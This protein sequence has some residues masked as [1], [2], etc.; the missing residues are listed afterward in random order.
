[1][2]DAQLRQYPTAC[3]IASSSSMASSYSLYSSRP[4]TSDAAAC[5]SLHCPCHSASRQAAATVVLRWTKLTIVKPWGGSGTRLRRR[6]HEAVAAV[7]RGC[8][9]GGTRLR[10]R[11][12]AIVVVLP[13][14]QAANMSRGDGAP[15]PKRCHQKRSSRPWPPRRVHDR[16]T[17]KCHVIFGFRKAP[18]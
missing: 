12:I 14:C 3:L 7:A 4:M 1:M 13:S 6:W 16:C 10:R 5:W 9:G 11:R 17:S 8:S 15:H 18:C 2:L